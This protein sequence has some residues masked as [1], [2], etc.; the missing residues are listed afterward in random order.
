MSTTPPTA[1]ERGGRG[2]P[3]AAT[4]PEATPPLPDETSRFSWLAPLFLAPALL[5][6]VVFVV[7]PIGFS[8]VRSLFDASG[9]SFVGIDNYTN[10]FTDANTATALKN[11]VIWVVVAPTIV[12]ALGL[13]FAVLTE[14]ISWVTV[15][16]TLVFMPM[17]VSF[18]ASGVIFRLVYDQEPDKGLANAIVVSVHDLFAPSSSY[19]GGR[20]SDPE[21][22]TTAADETVTSTEAFSTGTAV[23]LPLLAVTPE[24]VPENAAG[25]QETSTDS[26]SDSEVSGTVWLDFT[27]GGG[28]ESGVI[29][30]TEKGLPGI[31]VEAVKDAEVVGTTT[32]GDDGTF[33]LSGL[34][35]GDYQLRLPASN[36][37]EPF[38]G[39]TWLGPKLVTPA[40]IAAFIWIYAGFAMVLIA[41]GMAA[42]PREALEAARMDGATEWQ[43]FR[44]VTMP[45]LMPVLVVVFVTL[46]INVLKVFDLVFIIAPG[47][48]QPDANVLALQMW[49]VSFGGGQDQGLGSSIGIFL[50]LL[51][52]PA[53]IFNIRRFRRDQQ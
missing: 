49:K 37:E 7:Y 8:F 6:L 34:S 11:N 14:R 13:M 24:D 12:T 48:V 47:S 45:L 22:F 30:D 21:A 52:I 20:P 10:L 2:S 15:F 28:G 29:D 23:A 26:V 5:L 43:V 33:T 53:M 32:T 9:N 42:I 50:L 27:L 35:P 46:V 31:V 1:V 3:P 4:D 17:A 41:A 39:V 36:F 25:A 44:R 16:K 40:I 18:L 38:N 51:V 19:P